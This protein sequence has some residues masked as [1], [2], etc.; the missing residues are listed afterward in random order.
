[1]AAS[2]EY[3]ARRR[4]THASKPPL[5]W[6]RLAIVVA[7]FGLAGWEFVSSCQPA[8]T[9]SQ[10]VIFFGLLGLIWL[11]TV[12]TGWYRR[13]HPWE[14]SQDGR[15]TL[16]FAACS[17]VFMT[18]IPVMSLSEPEDRLIYILIIIILTLVVGGAFWAF[19]SWLSERY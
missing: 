17:M 13:Y 11:E 15:V 9:W 1:L 19:L 18:I 3:V 5:L 16:V 14:L 12:Q 7:A 4:P 8:P 6:W 2:I 10:H